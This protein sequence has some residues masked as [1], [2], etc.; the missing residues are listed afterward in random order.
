MALSFLLGSC[1]LGKPLFSK[2]DWRLTGGA[3]LTTGPTALPAPPGDTR[4]MRASR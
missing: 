4:G 1:P 3:A 2:T